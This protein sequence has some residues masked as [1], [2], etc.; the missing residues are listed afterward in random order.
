MANNR[1]LMLPVLA[2]VLLAR[3]YP[4]PGGLTSIHKDIKLQRINLPEPTP[5]VWRRLR[6][7]ALLLNAG[8]A[9]RC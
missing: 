1:G 4:A 7:D 6:T 3:V 2:T 8:C 5:G 9:M